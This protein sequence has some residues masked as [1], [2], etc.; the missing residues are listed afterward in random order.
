MSKDTL[1]EEKMIIEGFRM[2]AEGLNCYT[3]NTRS[4]VIF[5][6]RSITSDKLDI[7]AKLVLR[8][9]ARRGINDRDISARVFVAAEL[10][11]KEE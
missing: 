10:L 2:I 5:A 4:A 1:A 8:E 3:H 11:L 7:L 9:V 6:L